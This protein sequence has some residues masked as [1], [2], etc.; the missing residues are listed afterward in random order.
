MASDGF[1]LSTINKKREVARAFPY[2]SAR[3]GLKEAAWSLGTSIG[4]SARTVERFAKEGKE[5][6]IRLY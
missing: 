6:K 1:A 3:L 5:T 2:M 4:Y